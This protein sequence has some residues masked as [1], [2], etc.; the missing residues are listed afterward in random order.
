MLYQDEWVVTRIFQKSSGAKKAPIAGLGLSRSSSFLNDIDSPALPPLLESPY[1]PSATV[2]DAPVGNDAVHPFSHLQHVTCFSTSN[3]NP[4]IRN[5]SNHSVSAAGS[6]FASASDPLDLSFLQ[7]MMIDQVLSTTSSQMLPVQFPQPYPISCSSS[8]MP[9]FS[10]LLGQSAFP[11]NSVFK[12][13]AE[14]NER[15]KPCK[16]EPPSS[17]SSVQWTSKNNNEQQ[18]RGIHE[19]QASKFG[20]QPQPM[21]SLSQETGL[22]TEIN[23]DMSSVASSHQHHH[24]QQ[25][26]HHQQQQAQSYADDSLADCY[27]WNF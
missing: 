1:I 14:Q 25:L 12:S 2:N 21:V 6:A 7:S 27:G 5:P 13:Q 10:S 22:S 9:M 8:Y 4:P 17:T 16:I 20:G 18:Q 11:Q 26:S 23:T 19:Q 24:Q 3:D 15:L